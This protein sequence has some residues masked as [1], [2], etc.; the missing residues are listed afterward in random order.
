MIIGVIF[1]NGKEVDRG[2]FTG[3][4]HYIEEYPEQ[5][6]RICDSCS[7]YDAKNERSYTHDGTITFKEFSEDGKLLYD[8]VDGIERNDDQPLPAWLFNNSPIPHY[9]HKITENGDIESEFKGYIK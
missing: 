3:G 7:A 4:K 1:K 9:E 8:S 2:I 6:I 5:Y